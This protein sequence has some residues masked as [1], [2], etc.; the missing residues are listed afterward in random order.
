MLGTFI[1]CLLALIILNLNPHVD[2]YFFILAVACV[3]GYSML[4]LNFMASATFN[5]LCILLAFNLT[6]PASTFLIGERLVD[7]VIGSLV[8]LGCSYILPWW[9]HN[10][11]GSLAKAART[12]NQRFYRNGLQYAELS[13]RLLNAENQTDS[14]VAAKTADTTALTQQVHEADVNWRLARKNAYI[15]IGN[16]TSAFYRMMAEPTRCQKN[17][18]QVNHLLIQ[19]HLLASQISAA[20]PLLAQ[21]P[22]VPTGIQQSLDAIEALLEDRN[23]PIPVSIETEG[24]LAALAYPIRQ[25]SRAAQLI[26]QEMQ[27]FEKPKSGPTTP[28]AQ[29]A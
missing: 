6:A 11:M 18:P 25:M 22:A 1:G 21:L 9:E 8:A 2:I 3:L 13:R 14:T 10:F 24:D 29:P 5:T 15:A 27:V 17:V 7:T 20:I 23:A 19:N 12:A 26:H 4:Q 16:L 28:L